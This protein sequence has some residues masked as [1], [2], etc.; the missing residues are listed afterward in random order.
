MTENEKW[1]EY[2]RLMVHREHQMLGYL[3]S[4]A[5]LLEKIAGTKQSTTSQ[6]TTAATPYSSLSLLQQIERNTR[7]PACPVVQ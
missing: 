7:S 4:I 5:G 3:Q 2:Y 6:L 1:A